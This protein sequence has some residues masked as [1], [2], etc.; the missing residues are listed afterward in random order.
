MFFAFPG[1]E[2]GSRIRTLDSPARLAGKMV[3]RIS[4]AMI[5]ILKKGAED[6]RI[7]EV[8]DRIE[9]QGAQGRL[10][11]AEEGA[12][13]HVSGDTSMLQASSLEMLPGVGRVIR[14]TKPYHRVS[15]AGHPE[16]TIVKIPPVRHGDRGLSIGGPGVVIM[17]GPCSVEN[18]DML[19]AL[20]AF[21]KGA[22]A[23][24]LRGGAFKP[25][26]SPYDFQGLGVEGVRHLA[27]ERSIVGLP[28]ISE[29]VD[30][31]DV[32]MMGEFVDVLQVGARN[33]QNQS[34]LKALGR[35]SRPVLLKRGMS[36]T[37]DEWLMSA[38]YIMSEGN[39]QVILCERGIRTFEQATRNTLDLSVIPVLKRES[40]L[41]VVVDPSH[42][43]GQWDL[44]APM[45]R[46]A[47]A[48]GA[49]GVLLEVHPDPARA[50]SDGV[51]SL[52]PQRFKALVGELEL[53]A[54]AVGR[55]LA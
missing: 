34:L 45:A 30:A 31:R 37:V 9:K 35:S 55:N 43:V 24:L 6:A 39:S 7:Q 22:G 4:D 12:V 19:L 54:R 17:A 42:G 21:L 46:A 50:V 26:T 18:R 48:A 3:N 52:V 25:R 49:D 1:Q 23:H 47:V 8:M 11:S 29:V 10:F 36:S 20:A 40:H 13:I 33:M 5:I 38:E 41:P 53:V 44:V 14:I 28:V 15:A 32:E 16:K 51:Q 2:Q 27:E